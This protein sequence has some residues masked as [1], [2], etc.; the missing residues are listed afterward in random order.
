MD[1][2]DSRREWRLQEMLAAEFDAEIQ[3]LRRECRQLVALYKDVLWYNFEIDCCKWQ[4]PW[5][6]SI[7][8]SNVY[9]TGYSVNELIRNGCTYEVGSFPVWYDGKVS[10]A[11]RCPLTIVAKELQM[12][13]D[14][15]QR[16]E[17]A[18]AAVFDF[19]PG[20]ATVRRLAEISPVGKMYPVVSNSYDTIFDNA[21]KR[22]WTCWL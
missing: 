9:L 13:H 21:N 15:L 1:C 2:S 22:P 17:L 5:H 10:A 19:A 16:Y 18:Q 3:R 14:E 4:Q 6:T 7:G 11:P 20:T 8:D 12:A